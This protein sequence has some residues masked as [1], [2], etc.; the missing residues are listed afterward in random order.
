MYWYNVGRLHGGCLVVGAAGRA[1][2]GGARQRVAG[3]GARHAPR[4]RV[5]GGHGRPDGQR[6]EGSEG[7][8]RGGSGP[9]LRFTTDG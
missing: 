4:R 7:P 1:A 5:A 3:A 6:S 8:A 9:H 2:R